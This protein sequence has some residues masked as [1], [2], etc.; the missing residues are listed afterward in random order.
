MNRYRRTPNQLKMKAAYFWPSELAAKAQ[1][2]SIIPRLI[3][4]Q[5][6]FISILKVADSAPVAWK[7]ALRLNSQLPGNLFLKHLLVLS[8]VGG[9]TID[10]LKSYAAKLFPGGVMEYVWGG[11]R[12]HY[13][14][15]G[16][17][18]TKRDCD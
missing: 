3:A 9:E 14:L 1:T 12:Y 4:T 13:R 15:Q 16:I 10:R 8:D 2:T 17:P 6:Q 18:R 5:D 11:T 7:E